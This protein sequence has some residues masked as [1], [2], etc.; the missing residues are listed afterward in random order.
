MKIIDAIKIYGLENDISFKGVFDPSLLPPDAEIHIVVLTGGPC[1]GKTT[2]LN[3]AVRQ[4]IAIPNCEVFVAQE[5]ANHLKTGNMNFFS[6]GSDSTF[7]RLIIDHQETAERST[8][9]AAIKH[10]IAN[11]TCRVLCIFDRSLMDGEAYFDDPAEYAIILKDYGFDTKEMV[12]ARSDM[13]VY[14][15]SAAIGAEHA[16]TTNDGSTRREETIEQAAK[17]DHGVYEAWKHH[18]N[19]VE[20]DN[21]FRFN[22]KLDF[23]ISKIFSVAGIS[24]PVKICRRFIVPTPNDF[25]LHSNTTHL[26]TFWDK[27]I[28]IKQDPLSPD[29]YKS[30]RIRTGGNTVT[31][32]YS[33]QRWAK[34]TNPK[35][36][37]TSEEA[38]YD[39]TF[40]MSES[41]VLSSLLDMDPHINSVEKLV[42]TF[43]IRNDFYCELSVYECNQKYGYLRVFFDC[44]D[45]QVEYYVDIIKELFKAIREVTFERKYCEYEIARSNGEV[46]NNTTY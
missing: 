37:R 8:V 44:D 3:K 25:M 11:P 43:Y 39:T 17:L 24:M 36:N 22:E 32:N 26:E 42:R 35:T 34:V 1:A 46:L 13:V 2:T 30:V 29:L 27:S 7:Q 5:A 10:K 38:V 14:L 4:S 28:F 31:Y 12:Y 23:A 16:Y 33:E 18:K 40:P 9:I 6:C 41:E 15:R 45:S 20:V 21:S 19:F